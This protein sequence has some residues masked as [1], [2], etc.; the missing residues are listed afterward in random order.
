M[1]TR[2]RKTNALTIPGSRWLAY[3]SAGVATALAGAAPAEA[4]IHYSG[5]VD[6][7]FPPDEDKS[8]NFPLDQPGDLISFVHVA[9]GP[10]NFFGVRCPK[11]GAFVG[12]TVRYSSTTTFSGSGDEMQIAISRRAPSASPGLG[13]RGRLER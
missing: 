10:E 12:S 11:D 9:N 13:L 4:E 1:K 2:F 5:R 3:A 7:V 6:T 8:V